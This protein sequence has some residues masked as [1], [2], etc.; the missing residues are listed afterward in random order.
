MSSNRNKISSFFTYFFLALI[1][2]LLILRFTSMENDPPYF[3]ADFTQ[4]HLTDPYH[5]TYFARNAVLFG[6]WNPFDYHRW[7]V[8]KYSL[9]SGISYLL[10]V[11]FGVSRVTANLA[12][13][14][15]NVGGMLLFILGFRRYRNTREIKLTA[16]LLLISSMLFFYGRLPFLENG[17]IFLSGAAFYVFMKFYDKPWGNFTVGFLIAIA[18]LAGKLLGFVILAPAIAILIYAK[19]TKALT[20]S[21]IM[22]MGCATGVVM[23]S[24]VFYGGNFSIMLSYY[25]EHTLG[26]YGTPA[27][28][29]SPI[30][31]F[32]NLI[33]FGSDSNFFTLS[34]FFILTGFTG[35][36]VFFM[37]VKPSAP[38]KEEYLPVIFCI[39]WLIFG[40]LAL[41]PFNYRPLRY[42]VY[43][44]L[45]MSAIGGFALNLISEKKLTLSLGN[46]IISL[47]I[48]FLGTWY[49]LSQILAFFYPNSIKI[50]TI[51]QLAPYTGITAIIV[52]AI[53]YIVFKNRHRTISRIPI[54]LITIPLLLSITVH[55]GFL[56]YRG[57]S[58][59]GKYLKSYNREITQLISDEA[60]IT[61]P[62]APAFSIDNN[63]K[64][65]IYTFGLA[66]MDKD[67]FDKHPV[68]HILTDM[69]NW[70][71]ALEKYPSLKSAIILDQLRLCQSIVSLYMV[72]DNAVP[73]TDFE[74]A[75]IKTREGDIDSARIYYRRFSE[76]YPDNLTGRIMRVKMFSIKDTTDFVRNLQKLTVQ[77]PNNFRIYMLN[78]ECYNILENA[79]PGHGYGKMADY[80]FRHAVI[81]N[82]AL[83]KQLRKK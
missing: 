61:G 7:D 13:L 15:P 55:Q 63:L 1:L 6:D 52:T 81:I 17:L 83:Y 47:P 26:M 8:F 70:E 44:F 53:A 79:Y 2:F 65:I 50:T 19:R 73:K 40:I 51:Q 74:R 27:G 34:P 31:F 10:F 57:L 42:I 20:S 29:I 76:Q 22:L 49:F 58:L 69:L 33:T 5:I 54:M 80:Y 46:I 78:Y 72:P 23:Y 75:A 3:F 66:N 60:I 18:A 62:Y 56:I 37:I 12:G 82:P 67:F 39:A 48:I 43:L 64:G 71:I 68:T 45:P 9:V 35:I 32:L 16:F 30:S 36:V 41:G 25:M 21:L 24:L 4:A 14:L 59:P 77:Y 38:F 11:L 28:L